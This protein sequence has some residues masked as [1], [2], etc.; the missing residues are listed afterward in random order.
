MILAVK[1]VLALQSI[2]WLGALAAIS[3]RDGNFIGD[4]RII[5][6]GN[7]KKECDERL[8]KLTVA[9]NTILSTK[10][11][12]NDFIEKNPMIILGLVD[13]TCE[14]CCETEPILEQI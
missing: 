10:M 11:Q 9:R 3:K 2:L 4:E 14:K 13:S 12:Y 1:I 5:L 8:P 6:F 7:G